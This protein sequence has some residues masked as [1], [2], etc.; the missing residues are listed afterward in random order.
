[1]SIH[2]YCPL[3]HRLVVSD[4]RAGKKGRC[5][6]C[7]QRVFV[8]EPNPE[9]SGRPKTSAAMQTPMRDDMLEA[10]ALEE[11]GRESSDDPLSL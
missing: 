10:M 7:R 1:M 6:I 4:E 3:G 5:P 9:P 2:F 11:L 8:P